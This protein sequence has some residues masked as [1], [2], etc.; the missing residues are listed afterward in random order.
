VSI[1]RAI[2]NR[3]GIADWLRHLGDALLCLG[4]MEQAEASYDEALALFEEIGDRF[5]CA[6][7]LVHLGYA[8][9]VDGNQEAAKDYIQR[10]LNLY[11]ANLEAQQGVGVDKVLSPDFR[12]CLI[13]K[14]L[15]CVDQGDYEWALR[16]FSAA[17][18]LEPQIGYGPDL[19]MKERVDT[20]LNKVKIQIEA[21]AFLQA[22]QAGELMS[23]DEIV[24]NF[25]SKYDTEEVT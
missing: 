8:E 11:R 10:S 2:G 1:S 18:A 24:A 21:K 20:A 13:T 6:D 4:D 5:A 7:V 17:A 22:W 15:L 23:P 9:L 14:A 25:A 16:L 12:L 19:G 3:V